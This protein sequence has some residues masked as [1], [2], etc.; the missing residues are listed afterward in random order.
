MKKLTL[1]FND[2]NRD[3]VL[4]TLK[5]HRI[6]FSEIDTIRSNMKSKPI[7]TKKTREK[8]VNKKQEKMRKFALQIDC[9]DISEAIAKCGGGLNFRKRFKNEFKE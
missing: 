3:Y 5:T 8:D 7:K 9:K 2:A 4:H 6:Q 1:T